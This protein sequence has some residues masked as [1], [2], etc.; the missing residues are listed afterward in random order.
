MHMHMH[1]HMHIYTHPGSLLKIHLVHE[2]VR[3]SA[4]ILTSHTSVEG[5]NK[6]I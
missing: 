4:S 6:K 5:C 1:M 3:T 2:T